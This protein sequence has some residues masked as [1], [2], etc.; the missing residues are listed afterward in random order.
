LQ[1][2]SDIK[3]EEHSP[4]K[5]MA[6]KRLRY[7][8]AVS[9]FTGFD[10]FNAES[11][12][13]ISSFPE[14]RHDNDG[15]EKMEDVAA[16]ST[17]YEN[18][19]TENLRLLEIA[20]PLRSEGRGG[21]RPRVESAIDSLLPAAATMKRRRIASGKDDEVGS[22]EADTQVLQEIKQ[23]RKRIF[24][25]TAIPK[26][27][28]GDDELEA[29]S[30]RAEERTA[31]E[32]R[33]EPLTSGEIYDIQHGIEV[34]E[35]AL[36]EPK[37]LS[38]IGEDPRWDPRWNGRK[39]FKLFKK[40]GEGVRPLR[41]HRVTVRLEEAPIK[42]PLLG[43]VRHGGSDNTVRRNPRSID[44]N[45]YDSDGNDDSQFKRRGGR[46]NSND[47]AGI[48][49][50]AELSDSEFSDHDIRDITMDLDNFPAQ[51]RRKAERSAQSQVGEHPEESISRKTQI[52]VN[53]GKKRSAAGRSASGRTP[54][55]KRLATSSNVTRSSRFGNDDAGSGGSEDELRFK[56]RRR[57]D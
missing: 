11:Y 46:S 5:S 23:P 38:R 4:A 48:S 30:R 42:N 14:E 31:E 17:V 24:R 37:K 53:S 22:A 55:S 15:D 43:S 56:G 1:K 19:T 8:R 33:I 2:S 35:A 13:S 10:N 21:K 9:R 28:D 27:I 16:E 29:A 3:E 54:P 32:E 47:T 36:I 18:Q 39:N 7:G 26:D 44:N 52:S 45:A 49:T 25:K 34:K 41:G 40:R 6:S 12:P 57:R 20:S 51:Y 50:L